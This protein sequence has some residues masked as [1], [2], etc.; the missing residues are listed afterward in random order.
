MLW[1]SFPAI[2]AAKDGGMTKNIGFKV[3]GGVVQ[4][5]YDLIAPADQVYN[6]TVAMKKRFDKAYSYTPIAVS[7]DVGPAVIPG[8]NRRITWKITDE[9][10]NGLPGEDCFFVVEAEAG[11]AVEGGIP[12][13]V[14]IAGGA[15]VAGGILT[16]ILLS[17]SSGGGGTVNQG[18]PNPPGRP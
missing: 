15:A 2:A 3:T 13:Y 1:Y 11:S 10:P 16:A 6:V 18:F 17:K 12:T 8:E 7:G 4:V 14:W 5:Y 9:F